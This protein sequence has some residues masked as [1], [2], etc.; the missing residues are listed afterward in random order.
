M[1]EPIDNP[2]PTPIDFN[3][4][5]IPNIILKIT[6]I[7]MEINSKITA[8]NCFL[9]L[10]SCYCFRITPNNKRIVELNYSPSISERMS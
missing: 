5:K 4:V 6:I 8:K 2:K 1:V 9:L 10:I 7:K 3:S